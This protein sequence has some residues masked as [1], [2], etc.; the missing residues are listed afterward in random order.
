MAVA[1][2]GAVEKLYVLYDAHCVMCAGTVKRLQ[3]LKGIRAELQYVPLQSLAEGGAP[4]I[5]G[6]D[7]LDIEALYA[8]LHVVDG[9]GDVF[10]GADG[11]VRMM[12]ALPGL[13][14]VAWLYRIPGMRKAADGLYRFIANR[15]YDWFGRTDEGCADGA[16]R[17]Q[18][19]PT[20]KREDN[21]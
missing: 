6:R 16:C 15:R 1:R 17:L 10:A 7:K 13:R 11:V 4:D 12:R 18:E 2:G 3:A 14:P 5:P 19:P 8:K 20:P 9:A 21:N